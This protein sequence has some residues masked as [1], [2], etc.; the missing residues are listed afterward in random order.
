MGL[1]LIG[2]PPHGLVYMWETLVMS[3]VMTSKRNMM[4]KENVNKIR[5]KSKSFDRKISI[6]VILITYLNIDKSHKNSV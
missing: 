2:A 4:T 3:N 1:I 5:G 6:T